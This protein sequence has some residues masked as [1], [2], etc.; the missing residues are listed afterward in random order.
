M[1]NHDPNGVGTTGHEWDGI[2]EYNNPLPRWWL[3]I[4]Y[5]T[6]VFAAV[7]VVLYPALPGIKGNTPGILGTTARG[8]LATQM[9]AVEAQRAQALAELDRIA[10]PDLPKNPALMQAAVRGGEAAFKLHCSQCHGSGAAGG[11]GYPNL[12]DDDWIWGGDMESIRHTIAHG[13]RHEADP[14]TRLSMMPAFG[15]DGILN[16]SEISQVVEYV[17]GLSGAEHDAGKARRGSVIFAQQ[18]AACH[19]A[20]GEGN[21]DL[22]APNLANGIWLYGGDR[23]ALTYTVTNA[24]AGVMPA[25]SERLDERTIRKLTAYVHSLGG[26]E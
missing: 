18:C 21:R 25:W 12:N 26:G 15:R 19:G 5:A 3:Y 7:W 10:L 20:T 22:G 24:R 17:L 23:A 13:V 8:E 16:P 14:D 11:I 6:I 4:F 9:A 1:S 2:Q